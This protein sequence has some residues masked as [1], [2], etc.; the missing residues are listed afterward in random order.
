MLFKPGDILYYVCPFSFVID[1]VLIEFIDNE[2]ET[3]EGYPKHIYYIDHCGAYLLENDLFDRLEDAKNNSY[4]RLNNYY[5]V[6]LREI[7]LANPA[8][9]IEDND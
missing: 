4:I 5:A 1:K 7:S 3:L 9:D 6:K 2:G 8:L